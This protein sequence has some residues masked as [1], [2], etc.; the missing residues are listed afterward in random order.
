MSKRKAALAELS[1][2]PMAVV[3]EERP[4]GAR[5]GRLP[6]DRLYPNP[7]QPRRQF[8]PQTILELAAD[9][10]ANGL[11]Q[12]IRVRP[13]DLDGRHMIILG[14]RR[15]RAVQKIDGLSVT[16]VV[17]DYDI[18]DDDAAYDQA[19][20]ENLQRDDLTRTEVAAALLNRK[21]R[22]GLTNEA[23]A[24]RYHKSV[25]W[26][27]QHI[28][29]AQ[30]PEETR[31]LMDRKGVDLKIAGVLQSIGVEAQSEVVE[32]IAELPDQRS[33]LDFARTVRDL[34]GAGA[35]VGTA[36]ATARSHREAESSAGAAAA[37]GQGRP[38]GTSVGR[39]RAVAAPFE[40]RTDHRGVTWL[41]VNAQGLAT[42]RLIGKRELSP[43]SWL[44]AIAEDL[45]AFRG[46]CGANGYPNDWA[47]VETVIGPVVAPEASSPAKG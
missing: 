35:D 4:I 31:D 1:I 13:P 8:D 16:D 37:N 18:P 19:L 38:A 42:S 22:Y 24:V 2:A 26:V 21:E 30:L 41:M 28:R 45:S 43:A 3:T 11:L 6:I 39:P 23:L 25:A 27:D 20:A 36:L 32:A 47:L 44:Q 14:E 34:R 46:M 15:W 12:P 10:A 9:I 5:P 17:V 33:Q 40:L 7:N 29:Y